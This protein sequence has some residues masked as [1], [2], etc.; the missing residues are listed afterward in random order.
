METKANVS[1]GRHCELPVESIVIADGYNPR[2]EFEDQALFELGESMNNISQLQAV[3]INLVD[4]KYM[5]VAG[6]RRVRAAKEAKLKFIE[7][8]IFEDLD[9]LTS[10]RMMLAENR[11][12]VKLNPIEDAVGMQKLIEYGISEAEVAAEYA[13]N[14]ETVRRRLS[15]LKLTKDVQD[16]ITRENNPLPIHQALHLVK[17]NPSQQ[18][19]VARSAA[20]ITGPI[21]SESQV[22]EAVEALSGQKKFDTSKDDADPADKYPSLPQPNRKEKLRGS[23]PSAK[24][25]TPKPA[26]KFGPF[27]VTVGIKGKIETSRLDG[28]V[29][30]KK[31]TLTFKIEDQVEILNCDEMPLSFDVEGKTL[32]GLMKFLKKISA[33]KAK[34]AES[35]KPVKAGKKEA[36]AKTE[37]TENGDDDNGKETIKG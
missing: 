4:N 3:I 1:K 24:S 2:Q 12:R 17:L 31:A 29:L 30:L 22:K 34:E 5:L 16:M 36:A 18:L 19:K 11:N 23:S 7:A 27:D 20:P 21:A 26:E 9:P 6:E 32:A 33:K 35:K 14:I 10:L 37:D 8:K 28:E 15:L 13:V 25:S